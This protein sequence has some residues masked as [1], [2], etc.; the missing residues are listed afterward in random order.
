[1]KASKDRGKHFLSF[2]D[3]HLLLDLAHEI[4]RIRYM[5]KLCICLIGDSW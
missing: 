4:V 2:D 5:S 1:L 3:I